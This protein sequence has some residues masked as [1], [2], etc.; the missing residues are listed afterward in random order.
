MAINWG[1][2]NTKKNTRQEMKFSTAYNSQDT[3]YNNDIGS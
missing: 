2:Q 3:K 1:I